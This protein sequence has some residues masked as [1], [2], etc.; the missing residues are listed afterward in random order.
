M[1]AAP[2]AIN[3]IVTAEIFFVGENGAAEIGNAQAAAT[4]GI[5][6]L[7]VPLARDRPYFIIEADERRLR[8]V[9]EPFQQEAYFPVA[10]YAALPQTPQMKQAVSNRDIRRQRVRGAAF[11][12]GLIQLQRK[13]AL[14][15]GRQQ[16][17]PTAVNGSNRADAEQKTPPACLPDMPARL[18]TPYRDL[19]R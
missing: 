8:P 10:E 16:Q 4:V 7:V 13:E 2:P 14:R 17:G 9:R 1:R 18:S 15:S 3:R 12:S 5:L 6:A 11:L 19:P